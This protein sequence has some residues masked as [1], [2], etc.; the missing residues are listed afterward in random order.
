MLSKYQW[1]V[2]S[3]HLPIAGIMNLPTSG[4]A[5]KLLY[6]LPAP[7]NTK[8]S[9][10]FFIRIFLSTKIKRKS[11]ENFFINWYWY[12]KIS[13]NLL[14]Q[15]P[16]NIWME[17]LSVTCYFDTNMKIAWDTKIQLRSSKWHQIRTILLFNIIPM[18]IHYPPK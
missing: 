11:P 16:Y 5:K 18:Y 14:A 12:K 9:E 15:R 13:G 7:I 4:T 17:N 3:F 1:L 2:L 10:N 6:P 8:T